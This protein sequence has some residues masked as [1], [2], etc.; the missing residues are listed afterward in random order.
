MSDIAYFTPATFRFLRALARN[1]SRDWFTAHRADYERHVREPFLTL[2][3]DLS[4]PLA[5]IS[6][7]YRAD[8]RKNGGSLYRIH[9]D[10]RYSHNKLPYKTWQ[11][12]RFFHERRRE[13]PAPAFYLHL[14]PGDC[15]AGGGMWHPE[16]PTLKNL[17]NFLANN[18]QAWKRATGSKPFRQRL[19]FWGEQLT[20][21]PRG[22]DPDHELIEDLKRK[23]FAAG[24]NFDDAFACSSELRPWV[25]D[26]FKHVAPMVDYLCA[27]QELEF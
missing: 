15:F 25:V 20:R 8:V 3:A 12:S 23:D 24:E 4:A 1:N 26:S 7:H 13:I 22:F 9:R 11:G 2:I 5:S 6:Q 17:R 21:P 27:A 14:E 16:P 10:T 19:S 18:P